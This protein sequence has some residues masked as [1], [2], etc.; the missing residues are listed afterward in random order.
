MLDEAGWSAA[1]LARAV[2]ALGRRQGMA[3]R[4]DRTSVAHW[5]VG[6]RP[7]KAVPGLVAQALSRRIGRL[8]ALEETGLAAGLPPLAPL[9]MAGKADLDPR[10]RLAELCRAESDPARRAALRR[11]VYGAHPVR[12]PS[13]P[14]DRPPPPPGGE[15]GRSQA[16]VSI[17]QS[18][19]LIFASLIDSSGGGHARTALAAYLA[20]DAVPLLLAPADA[21]WHT[22]HLLGCSQLTHLL[23]NMTDDAGHHGLAQ[24][25]YRLALELAHQAGHRAAYATTLRALSTQAL[26]LGFLQYSADLACAAVEG[27]GPAAANTRAFVLA[28][29]ALVHA[30]TGHRSQAQ[31]DLKAAEQEHGRAPSSAGIFAS[32]PRAGLDYQRGETFY[33]LGDGT[34]ALGAFHD[35]ER[36]RPPAQRRPYAL[37]Q[38]RLAEVLAHSGHLEEACAHWHVFLD[39]YPHLASVHVERAAHTLH[40]TVRSFPRQSQ[41]RIVSDRARELSAAGLRSRLRRAEQREASVPE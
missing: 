25:Y 40:R 6:S 3:L 12:L 24:V 14:D 18:M 38:A 37:A 30:H 2:N 1:E 26:R 31:A 16:E 9:G 29:R 27:T 21:R 28:Q 15:G 5:L 34:A 36:H 19:G 41:A 22:Q 20:D 33:A 35:A 39:H 23:A 10:N 13:W 7:R 4:Y 17:L 8:V 32:Y 11:T